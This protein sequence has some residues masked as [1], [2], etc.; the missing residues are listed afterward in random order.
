MIIVNAM[1]PSSVNRSARKCVAESEI[2]GGALYF[3]LHFAEVAV[4]TFPRG[5]A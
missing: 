4:A 5:K 3:Y 2:K 1:D